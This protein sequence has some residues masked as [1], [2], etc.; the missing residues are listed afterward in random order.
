MELSRQEYPALLATLHPSQA[1][2]VLT[3]RIRIINKIHSDI[4]DF[5][6]ERRRV[7]EAYTQGLRK[8]AN[9]P[10]LDNGAALGV[11]QIPWQRI[12]NATEALATS[13]ETLATKIEEDVE[14]PLR[15]Y[16]TKNRDMQSMPGIQSNL[17]GLAKSIE[18]AQDKVEKAK[19]KSTKNPKQLA[20]A[21]AAAEEVSQQ[22]ESRAPFVFEQLQAADE[23]RLNHLRDVL[24]QL[25]THEVDQVERGRQAAESCLNVLLNVQTA[26]E[27]QTFAAKMK[28]NRIPASPAVPRG[29][30]PLPETPPAPA[31][32][33]FETPT[34]TPLAP[35]SR[36][37]DD[38][39]SER[40]ERS[41]RQTPTPTPPAPEPQPRN[42]ALGGLRRLG[43]VMG[44]RKSMV[45]PSGSTFDRKA[46]K[47]RSPFAPFKRSDS[48]RDMQIPESPPS[49]ADHHRGETLAPAPMAQP[50]P[51]TTN[52]TSP[53]FQPG[54]VRNG[55]DPSHVDSEGFTERPSTVD[56]VTRA[57][58]E[59]A[60]LDESG[61]NLT[62]RDQPIFEDENQAKQAMDDMANTLRLRAPQSVMRRNAGTIR[63]R[64]DV[65]NT[66]FIANPG[67]E[68][69]PNQIASDAYSP[70][71]PIRHTPSLSTATDDHAV[72]D[73]TS[74]R[75]GHTTHG[76][77]F[78][79]H[80]ELYEPG[81]NASIIETVNAWFSEGKVTKSS[82]MGELALAHNVAPG[83]AADSLRIRLD[84]F[85]V[86]EKVAA[87]PHFVQETS[88]DTSDEKR[89]EY[90]LQLGSISRPMP[91]VA[92]KYQL[93]LD[94]S[95]SSSYC[96]VIFKPAWNLQGSQASAIIFYSMNPAFVSQPVESITLKNVILTVGLDVAA[97]DEI[98]KQPRESVAHATSA[99]M[100]PN[101]GA[102][103]RRKNSTVTWRIPELE[104]KAPGSGDDGKFLVRFT[105]STPGPRKGNVEAKFELHTTESASRLGVSRAV[106][107]STQQDNDPFADSGKQSPAPVNWQEVPTSRKLVGGKYVSS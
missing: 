69:A 17:A 33:A 52:G 94:P 47:K 87:N 70:S 27:I 98:T 76:Q 100:H 73:T 34:S 96:P 4:A 14:R 32:S 57:Q 41:E 91:T 95:N 31:Q 38:A 40:S 55:T 88:K 29:E 20:S 7:E 78:S 12:I 77:T 1:T 25:E 67:S 9:R 35:P 16:S 80:P 19:K 68:L 45:I 66:V 90:D 85:P 105:T 3:D 22:W 61:M 60:G 18:A 50:F 107:E 75:S 10:S 84:N 74:V 89:G 86:L 6:Q 104:V 102:T 62:I 54:I 53:E 5:L 46:E 15:E 72:S 65:R 59:A 56:E 83:F 30:P 99:V 97:E 26:D 101:S 24:T 81:L 79:M 71:S 13:H 63:G 43:T 93:H 58:R 39:S 42:T 82:V 2:N 49:T 92:F 64:R 11:F 106:S 8:L 28:G 23:G 48:S 44:R 103:F 51:T 21:V 37:H 36:I